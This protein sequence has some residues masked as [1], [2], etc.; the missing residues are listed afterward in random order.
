MPYTDDLSKMLRARKVIHV[1]GISAAVVSFICAIDPEPISGTAL[2]IF[3]DTPL[4]TL[5][6]IGMIFT[7]AVIY[8]QGNV[9]KDGFLM[10]ASIAAGMV[11]GALGAKILGRLVPFLG[12]FNNAIITYG[13]HYATGRAIIDFFSGGHKLADLKLKKLKEMAKKYKSEGKE[14]GKQMVDVY[15]S[16][17]AS[18]R[19]D[20]KKLNKE[21]RELS[22]KAH[23]K[24]KENKFDEYATINDQMMSI[25]EKMNLIFVKYGLTEN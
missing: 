11:L 16:M 12:T 3:A 24:Q 17:D 4:V 14:R 6:T 22:K 1:W 8:E 13:L 5:C 21:F 10:I 9:L 19:D 25:G 23:E 20:L 18:D 15:K 7:L 2:V